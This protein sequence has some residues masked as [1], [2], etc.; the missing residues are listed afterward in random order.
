MPRLSVY[1]G[2]SSRKKWMKSKK[3]YKGSQEE[4]EKKKLERA[5]R[6]NTFLTDIGEAK[7]DFDAVITAIA[8]KHKHS[9]DYI[10]TYFGMKGGEGTKKCKTNCKNVL[11]SIHMA[12]VNAGE[13]RVVHHTTGSHC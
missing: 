13:S 1:T 9:K 8:A 3:A 2:L 10:Q 12:E 7:D 6:N 5:D 4:R 11:A